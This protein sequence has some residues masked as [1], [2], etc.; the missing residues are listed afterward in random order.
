M[1]DIKKSLKHFIKEVVAEEINKI[2]KTVQVEEII[3][4]ENEACEFLKTTRPTMLKLRKN[5]KVKYFKVGR[6]IRY[7]R[8]DLLNINE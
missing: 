3:Y 7:R 5:E 1:L 2:E 8:S 4:T 6:E